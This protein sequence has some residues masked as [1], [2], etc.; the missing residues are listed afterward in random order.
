[1]TGIGFL[2]ALALWAAG[3]TLP[4]LH[5]TELFVFE[6]E[7]SLIG[8]V[9]GL[10]REGETVIGLL[11]LMFTLVLPPC[12]LL[13]GYAL[14]RFADVE[15]TAARRGIALLDAIGKWTMLDVLILA[16]IVVTLKSS[17]VADVR[18]GPGLYFF[19]GSALLAL[20]AGVG[21]RR[22]ATLKEEAPIG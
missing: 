3:V 14:W 17:W 10:L 7:V 4:V 20:A 13:F 19:A 5:V 2:V 21:L 9:A 12:K 22:A 11:V 15:G 18:T 8:I 16:I 6:N 1:M